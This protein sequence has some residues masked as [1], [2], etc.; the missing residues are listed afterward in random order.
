MRSGAHLALAGSW[1]MG[2]LMRWR[3]LWS[4]GPR[5]Q[6]S[7][8]RCSARCCP[9]SLRRKRSDLSPSC[10]TSHLGADEGASSVSR[11]QVKCTTNAIQAAILHAQTP[12]NVFLA[13]DQGRH[14]WFPLW[15]RWC[16]WHNSCR[17]CWVLCWELCSA[18]LSL[19]CLA[20]GH[21]QEDSA[22]SGSGNEQMRACTV[23]AQVC[24][25]MRK[26]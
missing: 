17:W 5:W 14:L 2:A 3:S 19:S 23:A 10:F 1:W 11:G 15:S 12:S 7:Q 26:A 8:G 4:C 6:A 13:S 25:C 24:R 20:Q 9:S 18:P 21:L 16:R 22:A